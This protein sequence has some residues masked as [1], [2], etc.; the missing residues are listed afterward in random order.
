MQTFVTRGGMRNS[1]CPRS[2]WSQKLTSSS[3]G[4]SANAARAPPAT[5]T[6]TTG[7]TADADLN[8]SYVSNVTH[9]PALC[10]LNLPEPHALATHT[11]TTRWWDCREFAC[12]AGHLYPNNDDD[13]TGSQPTQLRAACAA[14]SHHPW[15]PGD[16]DNGDKFD[17]N[18]GK[19]AATAATIT[20][21][22]AAHA[23]AN[24]DNHRV[25]DNDD[26]RD[27]SG[28]S[29]HENDHGPWRRRLREDRGLEDCN[30]A[31]P[32]PARYNDDDHDDSESDRG[33]HDDNCDY[34]GCSEPR[35]PPTVTTTTPTTTMVVITLA[36]TRTTMIMY[37][38]SSSTCTVYTQ[39]VNSIPLYDNK[40][41]LYCVG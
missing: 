4:H 41:Y 17:H 15:H 40:L 36:T 38:H 37:H 10:P 5:I 32:N 2:L 35:A 31:A 8:P 19:D 34:E 9:Q 7:N 25:N 6:A 11:R 26:N 14:N 29:D 16:D 23:A 18:H 13:V 24:H 20:Q 12:G 21:L 28:R 22:R 33:D 39:L 30:S 1:S 27:D 3:C